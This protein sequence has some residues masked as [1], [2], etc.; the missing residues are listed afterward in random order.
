M[1][2]VS[3]SCIK[4]N[5]I[6]KVIRQL[7]E[8][9]INNI[10]LSG[11][12]E[13][14]PEIEHDLI[15]LKNA[16]HLQYACHAY[17]PPPQIPFV[18][19]LASCNDRIYRQSIGHYE[20]CIEMLK[21]TDC[22]VLSIHA[23]FLVEIG[24]DELGRKLS[25]KIVYDEDKAYDRFCSAYN[26]IADLCAKNSIAFF[27][28][29]NVLS[30]ENYK[31]F[32]YQNYLMMTDYDSIM[33]MRRQMDFDLLLDL[34]HLYVSSTTL[35]LTYEDECRKLKDYIRWIHLSENNGIIDEHKPL[36]ES[37]RILEQLQLLYRPDINITLET[38]GNIEEI[39]AGMAL[40]NSIIS[41]GKG[42]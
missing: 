31:Q 25:G 42:I 34:A 37:S 27:L 30:S 21:R 17:F 5:N 14:Y 40:V 20:H 23:G 22:H 24:T 1:I 29:N 11:G 9:G 12:T 6:A 28:E 2:Y 41:S 4:E 7:A 36:K 10:E 32:D 26:Y 16:H 15:A 35:N 33:K 18:V 19:N 3:S 13:Y 39:R 8:S 38:Q